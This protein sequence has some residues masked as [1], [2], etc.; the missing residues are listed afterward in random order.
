MKVFNVHEVFK[1]ARLINALLFDIEVI[2][3]LVYIL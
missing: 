2:Y 1:I 3:A